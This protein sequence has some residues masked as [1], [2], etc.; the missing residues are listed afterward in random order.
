MYDTLITICAIAVFSLAYTGIYLIGMKLVPFVERRRNETAKIDFGNVTASEVADGAITAFEVAGGST[1]TTETTK[2]NIAEVKE[3]TAVNFIEANEILGNTVNSIE[4]NEI[5]FSRIAV[6]EILA[7][8]YSISAKDIA[9]GEPL[10][11]DPVENK[12]K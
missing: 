4:A 2:S 10:I 3:A 8:A 6:P 1:G 5:V 7:N 11:Y 12:F 9:Y